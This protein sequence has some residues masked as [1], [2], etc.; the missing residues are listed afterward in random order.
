MSAESI[1]RLTVSV[2]VG[3]VLGLVLGVLLEAAGVVDN[4]FW[5]VAA[6]IAA[7]LGTQVWPWRTTR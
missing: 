3:A 6:M 1:K 7:A 2:L 4:P 5:L